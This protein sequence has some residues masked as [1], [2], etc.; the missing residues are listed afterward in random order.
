MAPGASYSV[1]IT[2]GM[3]YSTPG[4]F[5]VRALVTNDWYIEGDPDSTGTAGDYYDTDITV[6]APTPSPTP[7]LGKIGGKVFEDTNSDGNWDK[8]EPGIS[9]NVVI[10]LDQGTCGLKVVG[11]YKTTTPDINGN[12]VFTDLPSGSYCVYITFKLVIFPPTLTTPPNYSIKL[13]IGEEKLIYDF[14]IAP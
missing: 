6:I 5:T 11:P 12:Y 7:A 14:G 9:S 4:T 13:G 2:P 3:I 1:S 8:G 10:K